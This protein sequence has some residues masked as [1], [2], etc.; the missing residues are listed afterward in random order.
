MSEP[1]HP[2]LPRFIHGGASVS[3]LQAWVTATWL[4]AVEVRALIEDIEGA[5]GEPALVEA[6]KLR[7][8]EVLLEIEL[9]LANRPK[10][11]NVHALAHVL[12][13]GFREIAEIHGDRVAGAFGLGS[14]ESSNLERFWCEL[15]AGFPGGLPD[16]L[17]AEGQGEMLRALQV[18]NRACKT[19]GVE[20]DFLRPLLMDV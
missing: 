11:S 13:F 1:F 20:A 18:W 9:E 6:V 3:S 17:K 10:P 8:L 15:V 16:P 5:A 12:E 2:V 14:G 4:T 7:I 19:L